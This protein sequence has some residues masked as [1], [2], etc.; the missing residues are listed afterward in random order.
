MKMKHWTMIVPGAVLLCAA[1]A[2]GV[3]LRDAVQA[4]LNTNPDIR[5]A[6]HNK[7]A[8]KEERKQAEGLWYPRISV[9]GSAG[10]RKLRNP[11]RRSL[12]IADQRLEPI[13]GIVIA[14]Q[15]L[16]DMGGRTAEIRRQAS[17]TDAAAARIEERSE[18]VALNVSRAYIDYLLQQ[19]LVA[20]AQDNATFHDR[21]A[22]DLREGVA[23]GSISVADQQQAEERLQSARARLT[24]AQ[25][26]LDTAAIQFQTLTGVP[27]DSVTMPPDL[28]GAMPPTLQD[29]E[30]LARQQNPRVQE[31]MADLASARQ[32]IKSAQSELGPRFNL[33]GSA[34]YGDDI[35]GFQGRTSDL[36]A[37][38]VM[39]WKIFDGFANTANVREQKERANEVHSRLFEMTRRA[40]EDTRTA[41]S[42]LTNQTRLVGELETQGRVA[43]DLLLSYREQ[44]N[45][46]RRSLL[47]VL[48]AQNTRFN[49]QASAETARLARVYAQYRVLAATNRLIEALGVQMPAEAVMN[50]RDK[51][52]VNPIPPEDRQENSFPY[53][54]MG[55]PAPAGG[56]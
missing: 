11:T 27:I 56:Q 40:E 5:Q 35:D 24:E 29:A 21:L 39:R 10:L 48:D 14:D 3:E 15:L 6:V 18:F 38:V 19:R 8:T 33:E 45:V 37:R 32:E 23:R 53:P 17:R 46:G 26:D 43:D 44:F 55:P 9:E 16:F 31:A 28:S 52:G 4:A 2:Y 34:R 49:V 22:G 42:R 36:Q 7:L 25:E 47:D 41:W 30:E 50:Q 13:E 54:V 51:F 12:G 20:I 1:P